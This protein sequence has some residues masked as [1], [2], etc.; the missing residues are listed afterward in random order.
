VAAVT[1]ELPQIDEK[2][3]IEIFSRRAPQPRKGR[4]G[5]GVSQNGS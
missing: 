3:F 5:Q 2:L 1:R 4:A